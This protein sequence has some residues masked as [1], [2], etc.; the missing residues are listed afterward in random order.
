MEI[1]RLHKMLTNAGIE[2]EWRAR[3]L[4]VENAGWQVLIRDDSG[5]VLLSAI[6]GW[7]T[8]GFGGPDHGLLGTDEKDGD[9][10]E[11][12]G[13]LTPEEG[14]RDSV[15]GYLTAEEVLDRIILAKGIKS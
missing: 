14:G 1:E 10:I 6:E 7:G 8:Y 13:C 5:N 9:L 3:H 4:R 11:I 12:M 15:L 2:H